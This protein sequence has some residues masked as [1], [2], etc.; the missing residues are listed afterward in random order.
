MMYIGI[1][2]SFVRDYSFEGL[3]FIVSLLNWK[4][5]LL[6]FLGSN[7]RLNLPKSNRIFELMRN[8]RKNI[9]N[10]KD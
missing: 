7:I 1:Y 5:F 10:L 6:F 9:S 4:Y 2:N 8:N 3:A